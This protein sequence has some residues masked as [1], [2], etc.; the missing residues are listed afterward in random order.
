MTTPDIS[1]IIP[2][3][4]ESENLPPLV[5]RLLEGM[6]Q[7]DASCEI[8]IVND[9]STDNTVQV[10]S[11][12]ARKNAQIRSIHFARNFGKEAALVAGMQAACGRALLFLDADLQHPPELAARMVQAWRGGAQ[13]V[14]AVKRSRGDE[15]RLYRWFAKL[16]NH[17]MSTTLA[18]D[19]AG[20][21]DYKLLDRCV[22]QAICDCPEHVRFFRG[23]V[24]WVGF[25]QQNIAFDV[26]QRHKGQTTWAPR[27]LLRY[28]L[29]NL[30]SFSSAPLYW[31]AATGFFT[32]ALSFGL[33]LQTLF[34]YLTHDAAVGFTTVISL[35]VILGGMI[36]SALGVIA[37]YL[38]LIYEE[39]KRRPMYIIN[40]PTTND[41][42]H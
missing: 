42:Y 34:T 29:R 5:A 35:Q 21:S 36:L 3:Y 30:L 40:H 26:A 4:N 1:I 15:P 38:A 12:L 41:T 33:L 32:A 31:V 8:I 37:A 18:V 20:A 6:H 17:S 25:R 22:V 27:A 11:Q 2:A 16:F 24:A 23:L 10:A 28:T 19:M 39:V 9:G 14:N 13:V 7:V